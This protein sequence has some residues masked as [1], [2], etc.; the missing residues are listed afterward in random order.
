MSDAGSSVSTSWSQVLSL[1]V[2]GRAASE[3]VRARL[4]K[5]LREADFLGDFRPQLEAAEEAAASAAAATRDSL[6][7]EIT[8]WEQLHAESGA[9]RGRTS[10]D[11]TR[12]VPTGGRPWGGEAEGC[13]R[14]QRVA[15]RRVGAGTARDEK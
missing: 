14:R 6:A 15:R 7:R 11:A 9:A 4:T 5:Y 1:E 8:E 2:R 12:A 10:V 3:E 13:R